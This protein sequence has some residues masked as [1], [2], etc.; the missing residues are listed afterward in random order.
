MDCG[1]SNSV[2]ALKNE[3][4]RRTMVIEGVVDTFKFVAEYMTVIIENLLISIIQ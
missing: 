4:R 3:Q 1:L 2:S